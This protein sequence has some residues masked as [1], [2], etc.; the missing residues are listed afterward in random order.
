MTHESDYYN[1]QCSVELIQ[2]LWF[3]GSRSYINLL[4]QMQWKEKQAEGKALCTLT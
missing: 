4:K 1:G 2:R 3:V